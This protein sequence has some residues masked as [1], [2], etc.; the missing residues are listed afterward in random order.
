MM[1]EYRKYINKENREGFKKLF[2]DYAGEDLSV[3]DT[4]AIILSEAA[5]ALGEQDSRAGMKV[6]SQEV[7]DQI[8]EMLMEGIEGKYMFPLLL[9]MLDGC[10][11]EISFRDGTG[12]EGE[13]SV[14]L[15]SFNP[16]ANP[17]SFTVNVPE[18][19][20]EYDYDED[21][22]KEEYE[23]GDCGDGQYGE[24]EED[25]EDSSEGLDS[26]AYEEDEEYG[27]D[28]DEYEDDSYIVHDPDDPTVIWPADEDEEGPAITG[29]WKY[30]VRISRIDEIV[31]YLDWDEG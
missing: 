23:D 10:D 3:Q 27:V 20:D 5:Y 26:D 16:K 4:D 2:A 11:V 22:D 1:K 18:F 29:F 13:V 8:R 9:L 15:Q 30:R 25:G 21:E 28:E 17:K 19:D 12:V 6:F 7:H 24:D 14:G 31:A